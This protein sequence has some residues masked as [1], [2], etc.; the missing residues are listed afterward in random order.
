MS[1]ARDQVIE[2]VHVTI[3][4]EGGVIQGVK[5]TIETKPAKQQR[6]SA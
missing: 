2:A 6:R 4:V 5:T 3:I 1:K